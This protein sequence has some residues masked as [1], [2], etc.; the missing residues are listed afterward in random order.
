MRKVFTDFFCWNWNYLPC[1]VPGRHPGPSFVVC[2]FCNPEV[3]TIFFPFLF[4]FV[5]CFLFFFLFFV[6]CF[7]FSE[8]GF[9]CV[10]LL[11]WNSLYRP[12]WPRNQKSA[13]LCL[14]NA[15]IKGMRH[16]CSVVKNILS[17]LSLPDNWWKKEAKH[18]V[19]VVCLEEGLALELR[20]GWHL[21]CNQSCSE[22]LT[23]LP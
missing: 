3:K 8:T 18:Q 22:P 19:Y 9:F 6:F 13:C 7:L 20:L 4:F 5:F 23:F 17:A 2:S 1:Q 10:A 15:G 11:S 12:G 16:H 21:L 14:P